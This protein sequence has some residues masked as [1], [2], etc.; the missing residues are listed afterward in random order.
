[1]TWLLALIKRFMALLYAGT[2]LPGFPEDPKDPEDPEEAMEPEPI[3]EAQK[4]Q[5]APEL[6]QEP[7][8]P[9]EPPPMPNQEKLYQQ[10]KL[11]LGRRMIIDPSVPNLL[12]CASSMSGV[13]KAAGYTGLPKLGIAGTAALYQHFRTSPDFEEANIYQRGL[14]LIYPSGQK[15]AM[16]D[17]GHVFVCGDYGLMSN[18]SETGKWSQHW[19]YP[20]AEK[21]YHT[22]GKLKGTFFRWKG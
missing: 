12:G 13:L 8:K 4:A 11:S 5:K 20:E 21:Y 14:I 3:Q 7:T 6:P 2:T 10:A 15:G 1:M 18:N 17:H 22:Q 19:T 16:L 9:V